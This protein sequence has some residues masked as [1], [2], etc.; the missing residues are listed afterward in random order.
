MLIEVDARE[1]TAA[2]QRSARLRD[3]AQIWQNDLS[4]PEQASRVLREAREADPH[5]PLLLGELVDTLTASGE[6]KAAAAELTAAIDTLQGDDTVRTDY[7]GR[8]AI[9]RSR[10][11]DHDGALAD[12]DEAVAKG[13]LDLR[14]YLAEHLGKM[15]LAAAG[16]GDAQ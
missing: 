13:K 3:A 14:P 11:N 5:D 9:L 6:L 12:F 1:L 8:R 4:D 2:R 16:R 15:A 7:V 10:L